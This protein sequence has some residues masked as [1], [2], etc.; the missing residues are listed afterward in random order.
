MD[1]TTKPA[2]TGNNLEHRLVRPVGVELGKQLAQRIIPELESNEA[3]ALTHDSSTNNLINQYRRS[4]E[5][6]WTRSA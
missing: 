1:P 5:A 3:P 6:L 2:Y 4:K